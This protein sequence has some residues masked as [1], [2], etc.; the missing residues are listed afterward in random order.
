MFPNV[1]PDL[2]RERALNAIDRAFDARVSPLATA[3][4]A[5]WWQLETWLRWLVQIE[6]RAAFG[7][8][9]ES[10]LGDRAAAFAQRDQENAYMPSPDQSLITYLDGGTLFRLILDPAH[11]P[12]FEPSLLKRSRWEGLSDELIAL[13]NRTAHCRRPHED[14]LNRVEQA[15]KTLEPG[16]RRALI[17]F[18]EQSPV[19]AADGVVAEA[20]VDGVHPDARRLVEHARKRYDTDFRL[21]ASARP[22]APTD[23]GRGWLWHAEWFIHERMLPPRS[24]WESTYLDSRG[25]REHIVQVTQHDDYHIAIAFAAADDPH[26]V[27]DSIGSCF[28]AVVGSLSPRSRKE[29]AFG[30]LWR[31]AAQLDARVQSGNPLF[32]LSAEDG[33]VSIFYVPSKVPAATAGLAPASTGVS[34]SSVE[35]ND[36]AAGNDRRPGGIAFSVAHP[37]ASDDAPSAHQAVEQRLIAHGFG[38]RIASHWLFALLVGIATIVAA[39]AA[40]AA[41]TK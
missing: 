1:E 13:R 19:V 38:A 9:W 2:A 3:I 39:V 37:I 15:L 34:S 21:M 27:A 41:L 5:R 26:A 7:S 24:F 28:D 23:L 12:L 14:D 6:L 35:A 32:D 8:D 22:W 40:I 29:P 17:A 16:A 30:W 18:N 20:W 31:E 36:Q 33:P 10:H 25:A 11:W 4:Y